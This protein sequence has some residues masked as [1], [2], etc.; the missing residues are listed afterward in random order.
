MN[1]LNEGVNEYYEWLKKRTFVQKDGTTGWSVVSTPFVGLFNDTIDLFVKLQPN[2]NVLLSDDGNTLSNLELLG[3]NFK[4]S[5][6]R[7]DIL[8]RVKLNYGVSVAKDGE[9]SKTVV[10]KDFAQ[11]KHDMIRAILELSDMANMSTHRIAS[12]FRD[13]VKILLRDHKINVT[14]G[15]IASGR[16]GLRFTFDYMIAKPE[17]EIVLQTFN[18]LDR[19]N[20]ATF[21]FGVDEVKPVREQISEK[22]FQPVAIINDEDNKIK[23]EYLDALR[24]REIDFMLW[25]KRNQEGFMEMIA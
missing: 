14:P 13:D 16:P 19:P 7:R 24:N 5:T 17:A 23:G 11:G 9:M 12:I 1:W 21:L 3:V 22:K 25:S 4:S 8:D 20:L 10:R 15:F 2:G 18:H 6:G